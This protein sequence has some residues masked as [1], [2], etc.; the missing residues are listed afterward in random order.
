[1]H[2]KFLF[3]LL[4]LLAFGAASYPSDEVSEVYAH[5]RHPSDEALFLD[6]TIRRFLRGVGEGVLLDVGCGA[7]AWAIEAAQ[8]G[9]LVVA[10]DSEP[11][12]IERGAA[13]AAEAGVA[14]K[15]EFAIGDVTHL[16]KREAAF[17][18]A[19]SVHVGCRL[20]SLGRHM[21]EIARLLRPDG[22]V[23]VTAPTSFEVLFTDDSD[24]VEVRE[25]LEQLP[26]EEISSIYRGTFTERNGKFELI[27]ETARLFDGQPI[28]CKV[29]GRVV[30]NYYHPEEA[31][32]DAFWAA[33][34]EV[35]AIHRPCF[36]AEEE[37]LA[38]GSKLGAAYVGS[39][40]FVIFE[41]KKL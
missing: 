28:W 30:P 36:H 5:H 19:I 23:L 40:P 3:C 38:H 7:G 6:G 39:P 32:L 24:P 33:G 4:S 26:L 10:I 17:D 14:D 16:P 22:R 34:L 15:I 29:P 13:A 35:V 37:R 2:R 20:P 1:M 18:A 12:M 11:A 21:R 27:R 9:A 8:Q 41:L 25:L 31:Y